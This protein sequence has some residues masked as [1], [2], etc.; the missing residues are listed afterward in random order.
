MTGQTKKNE[1][2]QLQE[3]SNVSLARKKTEREGGSEGGGGWPQHVKSQIQRNHCHPP[4]DKSHQ[5]LGRTKKQ[6]TPPLLASKRAN[7]S[8][9]RSHSGDSLFFVVPLDASF[10]KEE[11]RKRATK[12]L[13]LDD[14]HGREN[15]NTRDSRFVTPAGSQVRIS[16][17]MKPTTKKISRKG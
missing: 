1:A 7:I 17:Q 2:K 16:V 8:L 3:V 6:Q 4:R 13:N 12:R 5:S 10:S 11:E 14:S 15:C 9:S